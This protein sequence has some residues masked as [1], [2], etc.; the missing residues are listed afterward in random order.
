MHTCNHIFYVQFIEP[1]SKRRLSA[2]STGKT[3]RDDALLVVYKWMEDG[4]PQKRSKVEN[5]TFAR[6]LSLEL[7]TA[8]VLSELKKSD[9]TGQ[10]VLKI[11]KILKEKG[12]IDLIV[13]KNAPEA[14]PLVEYLR[15]FWDYDRSPYVEEKQSHKLT[16]GRTHTISSLERVNLYWVPFFGR[17]LLGEV[18]RQHIKE[19]SVDL[20]KKYEKL[21]P[22]T[23]K[24]ILRVGVT[25]LRWAFANGLIS[26]DPT[27]DLPSYSSKSRRRGVLTPGEAKALFS[28]KWGNERYKLVNLIAMTTGLRI[29]EILAI[30]END[31]G[32]EYINIQWSYSIKD[33]LKSTKTDEPRL[34]PVIPQIRDAMRWWGSLNPHG[35]GF[36]FFGE[37]PNQPFDQHEPPKALNKMLIQLKTGEMLKAKTEEEKVAQKIAIDETKAYWKKRN[38]VFHSWRHFYAARMTD[39]LEARKVMLATGHKT[40]SVFKGYSDHA[41]E[42]DLTDVAVTTGEVFG[43]I[44]PKQI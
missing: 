17:K 29:G 11:E 32:E 10:D 9:L 18:T 16:I 27:L 6:P 42:S 37:K 28:F 22:L 33:K 39:K 34:V 14:E 7:T 12:L 35:D 4:I 8:Q 19:F 15:R 5:S 20:A 44:I 40:E 38:V 43:G 41:L 31:I 24:Q 1:H 36:V 26:I 30:H 3:S 21:S 23:L 13:R 25:A 2:I